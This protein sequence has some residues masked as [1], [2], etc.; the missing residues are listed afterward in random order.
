M[1]FACELSTKDNLLTVFADAIGQL[2]PD[3]WQDRLDDEVRTIFSERG[4]SLDAAEM[5]QI[6][7]KALRRAPEEVSPEGLSVARDLLGESSMVTALMQILGSQP[8]ETNNPWHVLARDHLGDTDYRQ[9]LADLEAENPGKISE[10][11]APYYASPGRMTQR[12]LF[13]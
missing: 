11:A 3:E 8:R 2:P 7:V 10:P 9:L 12:R 1:A 4:F 5:T 13:D 6:L